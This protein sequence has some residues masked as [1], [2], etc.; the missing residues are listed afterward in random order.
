MTTKKAAKKVPA[1][2]AAPKQEPVKAGDVSQSENSMQ[3]PFAY[4]NGRQAAVSGISR[5]QAPYADGGELKAWLEGYDS[6]RV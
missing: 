2:K 4:Q 5:D 3:H 6:H 1:K